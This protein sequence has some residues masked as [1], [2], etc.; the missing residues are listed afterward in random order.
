M[1]PAWEHADPSMHW[2]L[3]NNTEQLT[4]LDD[5]QYLPKENEKSIS[6][7]EPREWKPAKT[8]EEVLSAGQKAQSQLGSRQVLQ[9]EKPLRQ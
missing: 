8:H 4:I 3:P 5:T 7:D 9:T 6:H 1:W 2:G